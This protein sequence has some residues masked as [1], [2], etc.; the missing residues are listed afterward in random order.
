MPSPK[1]QLKLP[2]PVK[3]VDSEFKGKVDMVP[4]KGFVVVSLTERLAD[5]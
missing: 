3:F 2:R 5:E 1:R 4:L